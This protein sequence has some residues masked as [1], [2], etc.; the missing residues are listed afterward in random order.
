MKNDY[1]LRTSFFLVHPV[2]IYI[3]IYLHIYIT[4]YP[5]IYPLIYRRTYPHITLQVLGVLKLPPDQ[6]REDSVYYCSLFVA[7][8]VTAA[9]A[10]FLQVMV[11]CPAAA[12]I[13]QDKDK[14]RCSRSRC[15]RWRGST[16][17]SAC[18]DSP[19]PPCCAR[20]ADGQT[21]VDM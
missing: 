13:R 1:V 3:S 14:T 20:T 8:G 11:C 5:H 2:H 12:G 15:S 10:V 17:P 16:S 6:A 18:G 9:V 21:A 19:S 7:A 4:T